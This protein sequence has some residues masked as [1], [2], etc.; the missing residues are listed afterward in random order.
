MQSLAEVTSNYVRETRRIVSLLS[1]TYAVLKGERLP[2]DVI[3]GTSERS[4]RRRDMPDI[5]LGDSPLFVGVHARQTQHL[6]HL[7]FERCVYEVPNHE[8]SAVQ[9]P[10]KIHCR[11]NVQLE[12]G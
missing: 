7:S 2:F 8:T 9:R 11:L 3:T 10:T 4:A 6:H 1:S 5:A 12:F